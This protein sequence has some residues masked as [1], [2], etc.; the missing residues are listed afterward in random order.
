MRGRAA[1]RV[2]LMAGP[3][4][5]PIQAQSILTR[6]PT[7]DPASHPAARFG[8]RRQSGTS[9]R[10]SYTPSSARGPMS[11]SSIR[12]KEALLIEVLAPPKRVDSNS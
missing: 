3:R 2:V 4:R 8:V 7:I 10:A 9:R 12:P 5:R 1:T 6:V 11:V